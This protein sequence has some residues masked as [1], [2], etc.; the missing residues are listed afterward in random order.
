M[1]VYLIIN[2]LLRPFTLDKMSPDAGEDFRLAAMFSTQAHLAVRVLFSCQAFGGKV[3][4]AA[5]VV[6][7]S[8]V[9]N[10]I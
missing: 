8:F 5:S 1:I 6:Y 4:V 10:G 3:T 9:L 7:G 2:V